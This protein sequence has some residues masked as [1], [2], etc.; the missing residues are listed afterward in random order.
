MSTIDENQKFAGTEFTPFNETDGGIGI[1]RIGTFV[2]TGTLPRG[3]GSV[4][5]GNQ[6]LYKGYDTSTIDG[7]RQGVSLRTQRHVYG[8]VQPKIWS[9]NLQHFILV[10]TLG[11]ARSFT[12]FDNSPLFVDI[13]PTFDTGS[14]GVGKTP[15][16]FNPVQYLTDPLYPFPIIFNNGPQQEEEAIIEPL[17]IAYRRASNEGNTLRRTVKGSLED[18]NNFDSDKGATNRIEQFVSFTPPSEPRFFL[19]EGAVYFGDNNGLNPERGI[20]IENFIPFIQREIVP[21]NETRNE[22]IVERIRTNDPDFIS[23]LKALKFDLDND[24]REQF[25]KKSATAGSDV[26]GPDAGYIGTDSIAYVGRTRGA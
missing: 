9:G 17:T 19:D 5:A 8:S 12:E 15:A 18:G 20:A 21:Y 7:L 25:D 14:I 24:I 22:R 16:H 13:L 26:Y 11:Q 23:V 1:E 6:H 10:R 4:A 3:T 2:S